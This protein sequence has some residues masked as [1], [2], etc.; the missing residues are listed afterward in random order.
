MRVIGEMVSFLMYD[1]ILLILNHTSNGYIA[2]IVDKKR[3]DIHY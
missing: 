3:F 1:F 2:C